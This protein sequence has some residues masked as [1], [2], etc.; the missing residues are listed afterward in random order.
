MMLKSGNMF[1]DLQKQLQGFDAEI[2]TLDSALDVQIDTT[3]SLAGLIAD[4]HDEVS[5]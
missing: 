2:H 1:I 4:K 3:S 5:A